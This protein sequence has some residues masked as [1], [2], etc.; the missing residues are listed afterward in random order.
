M[1]SPKYLR[2]FDNDSGMTILRI[3]SM[4]LTLHGI[5]S[6]QFFYRD[7]LSKSFDDERE[8]DVILMNPPFRGAVDKSTVHPTLPADTTKSELL[9]LHLILR[10]RY[11][12][13][14]GG[15]RA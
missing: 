12:R 10:A 1:S 13:T 8:Y 6:P 7:T 4:N 5:E 2:G 15:D 3:G 9:F 14:R 11:G